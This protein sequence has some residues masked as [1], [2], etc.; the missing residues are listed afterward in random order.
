M[1]RM[2]QVI[3]LK[4]TAK[5]EYI[6]IHKN[7][8][9]EILKILADANIRNYS[10]FLREPE[11][12]LIAYWEYHGTNFEDDHAILSGHPKMR[13]WWAITDPMQTKLSSCNNNEQ[14]AAARQLFFTNQ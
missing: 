4:D 5:R 8:W 6:E 2:A 11:N 3:Y 12:L 1:Q 14:W 13:E 9:P 7:V 10:I